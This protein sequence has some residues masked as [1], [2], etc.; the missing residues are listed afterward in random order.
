MPG[1]ILI[2]IVGCTILAVIVNDAA[3]LT[4]AQWGLIQPKLPSNLFATPDF[5]LLGRF[6]LFGGSR[7][8]A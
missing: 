4:A 2:S 3:H 7:T 1:A 8:Q 5:G 6:S